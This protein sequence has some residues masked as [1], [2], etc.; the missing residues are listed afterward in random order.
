MA[1]KQLALLDSLI[2]GGKIPAE[3][4]MIAPE[5]IVERRSTDILEVQDE[6]VAKALRFIRDNCSRPIGVGDIIVVTFLAIVEF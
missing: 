3:P 4:T 2:R 1:I 5:R 6:L